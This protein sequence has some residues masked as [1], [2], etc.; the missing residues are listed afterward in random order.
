MSSED[1]EES[2]EVHETHEEATD[3]CEARYLC[4]WDTCVKKAGIVMVRHC[5]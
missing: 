3:V 5:E 4:L 2:G 1:E